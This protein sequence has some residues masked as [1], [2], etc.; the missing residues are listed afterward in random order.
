MQY[1]LTQEEFD[2][3]HA[4]YQKQ[5]DDTKKKLIEEITKAIQ[6]W[7]PDPWLSRTDPHEFIRTLTEPL[8]Q[9]LERCKIIAEK[10][11]SEPAKTH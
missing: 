3:I 1:L 10:C 7:H 6:S 5:L 2:S 8:G 11:A 9:A 4:K